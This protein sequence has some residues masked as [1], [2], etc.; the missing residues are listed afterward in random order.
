MASN[1]LWYSLQILF[2]TSLISFLSLEVSPVHVYL[3]YIS[4]VVAGWV[5]YNPLHRIGGWVKWNI[6]RER[7]K[8]TKIAAT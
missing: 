7:V 2:F 5:V 4:T 8:I 3:R 1:I 6:I